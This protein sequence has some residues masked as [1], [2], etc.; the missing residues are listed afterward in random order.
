MLH[1][2]QDVLLAVAATLV[3]T[4]DAVALEDS[5]QSPT[6]IFYE[7]PV[8]MNVFLGD[9]YGVAQVEPSF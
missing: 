3:M 4:A 6:M 7:S 2:S 1:Y 8:H 5:E 9:T